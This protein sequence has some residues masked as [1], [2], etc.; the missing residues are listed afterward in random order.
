MRF[1]PVH[2]Q[3]ESVSH[4]MEFWKFDRS[5]VEFRGLDVVKIRFDHMGFQKPQ[6]LPTFTLDRHDRHVTFKVLQYAELAYLVYQ[7]PKDT[8]RL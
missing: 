4:A 6:V 1:Q 3:H 8:R 5:L 2:I 7:H